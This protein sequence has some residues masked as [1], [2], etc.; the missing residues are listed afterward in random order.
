MTIENEKVSP[1]N[2]TIFQNVNDWITPYRLAT[3]VLVILF[4]GADVSLYLFGS[5][6]TG[7]R[8]VAIIITLLSG[9]GTLIWKR[10]RDHN[11]SNDLQRSIALAMIIL[12]ALAAVIFLVGNFARGEW[13]NFSSMIMVDGV[14]AA[15]LLNYQMVAIKVFTWTIGIMA[16]V[17]ILALFIFQ[18]N[19]TEK[20]QSRVLAKIERDTRDA[21]LK[22]LKK[23]NEIAS[24][25]YIEH[26]D[27]FAE[28]K[29][30][31]RARDKILNENKSLPKDVI[32][33]MLAPIEKRMGEL[34]GLIPVSPS[35]AN[36]S[37]SA[38]APFSQPLPRT[39]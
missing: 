12:H 9:V 33:H 13:D 27:A 37:E 6:A 29:G 36:T 30:L 19:D 15:D 28:L 26:A 7:S 24:Q 3:F 22:A 35:S 32:D 11:K 34:Q 18:E 20:M 17:N 16:A 25:K 2:K 39:K 10:Q 23:E 5:E 1:E 21:E 14:L 4:I 31:N 8:I 38:A